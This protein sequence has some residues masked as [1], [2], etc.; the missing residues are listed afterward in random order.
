MITSSNPSG[1]S[2]FTFRSD[3]LLTARGGCTWAL[4]VEF[5]YL[6]C[7]PGNTLC[8]QRQEPPGRDG[9]GAIQ[10]PY[11]FFICILNWRVLDVFQVITDRMQSVSFLILCP[12]LPQ[13]N[14][15]CIGFTDINI[16]KEFG[17]LCM[18]IQG[19]ENKWCTENLRRTKRQ[20]SPPWL[21]AWEIKVPQIFFLS[22][23]SSQ[24]NILWHEM[25][26]KWGSQGWFQTAFDFG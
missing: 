24:D 23:L 6:P 14:S 3:L 10:T 17:C 11:L 22:S 9:I 21:P 5:A 25:K 20:R 1:G 19:N 7:Y 15:I 12:G 13:L 18:H 26:M 4:L 2:E 8:S 16:L